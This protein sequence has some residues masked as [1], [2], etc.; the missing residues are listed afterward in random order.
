[1][2]EQMVEEHQVVEMVVLVEMVQIFL[3]LLELVS[4]FV[5]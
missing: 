1:V 2:L 3:Q 5:V 4:E